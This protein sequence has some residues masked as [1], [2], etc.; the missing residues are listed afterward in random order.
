VV[1]G[2]SVSEKI[3]LL[4]DNDGTEYLVADDVVQQIRDRFPER[5]HKP[6]RGHDRCVKWRKHEAAEQRN[7]A[8]LGRVSQNWPRSKRPW[9]A[10]PHRRERAGKMNPG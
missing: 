4:H 2:A 9:P 3:M 5:L 1:L 10:R 8:L 7:R 6:N